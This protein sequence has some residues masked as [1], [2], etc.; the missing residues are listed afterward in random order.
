MVSMNS[1]NMIDLFFNSSLILLYKVFTKKFRFPF[2]VVISPYL[3]NKTLSISIPTISNKIHSLVYNIYIVFS[4]LFFNVFKY[5][6]SSL[7]T[8]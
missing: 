2:L 7:E 8:L 1:K 5:S 3:I 6:L 4:K